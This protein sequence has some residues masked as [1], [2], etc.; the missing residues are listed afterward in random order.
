MNNITVF[1]NQEFGCVRTVDVNGE[2]WFVAKDIADILGY[3]ETEKMTRRLDDDEKLTSQFGG[4]GQNRNMLCINESGLYNAI[5]GSN[6]PQAKKFKKWVTSEV[7]P[8]IRKTGG[9]LAPTVDFSNPENLMKLLTNW[10]EDRKKLEIANTQIEEDK[11]KVEFHDAVI[12]SD[13]TVDMAQVAKLLNMG[14]GRNRLF[15]LLRD[16]HI[17]MNNNSP[18]QY[19]VDNGWFRLVESRF[20]KPNGDTCINI[21]TVVFQKGIKGIK[22]IVEK[23]Q[24]GR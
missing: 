8:S 14:I 16:K 9:Y 24:D 18:Y 20:T 6:K 2:V 10:A 19:Y 1:E 13:D 12:G 21:K 23:E 4:T 15:Q 3:S 17:L 5:I 22:K 11:P 7:L